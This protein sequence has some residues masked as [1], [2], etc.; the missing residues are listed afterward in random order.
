[1][2]LTVNLVV[3]IWYHRFCHPL[4]AQQPAASG[5]SK[6]FKEFLL[7]AFEDLELML[8]WNWQTCHLVRSD[9]RLLLF[10]LIC[11]WVLLDSSIVMGLQQRVILMAFLAILG[12]RAHVLKSDF[13]HKSWPSVFDLMQVL[14]NFLFYS[15]VPPPSSDK[16]KDKAGAE[17]TVSSTPSAAA[18]P[19]ARRP[20]TTFGV[21][22]DAANTASDIPLVLK[23]LILL[24]AYVGLSASA[25]YRSVS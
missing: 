22:I 9:C 6:S 18:A 15:P 8:G 1:L 2:K 11:G 4:E 12:N 10:S 13:D 20:F 21:H 23:S 7:H 19:V 25:P 5:R 3:S 16:E 17:G 24:D 14:E